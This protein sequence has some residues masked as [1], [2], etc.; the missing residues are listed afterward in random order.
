M[1]KESWK[2][3]EKKGWQASEGEEGTARGSLCGG[4]ESFR[5]R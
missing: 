4:D 5:V 3:W 1:M 2:T